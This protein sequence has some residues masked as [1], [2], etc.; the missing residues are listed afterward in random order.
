MSKNWYTKVCENYYLWISNKYRKS[1]AAEIPVTKSL[2]KVDGTKFLNNNKNQLF[3]AKFSRGLLLCKRARPYIQPTI[4]VLCTRLKHSNK[5]DCYKLPKLMKYLVRTQELY[6][7]IKSG[8]T[9]CLKLYV[10]AAFV[11]YFYFKLH[12]GSKLSM[13]KVSI[14]SVSRKQKLNTKIITEADLVGVDDASSLILCTKLF[15]ESQGYK[16]DLS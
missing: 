16:V 12:T 3:H 10:D 11:V 7:A 5:G 4:A 15:L 1:Q 14:V 8:K 2:F 13:G 6:L 9:S